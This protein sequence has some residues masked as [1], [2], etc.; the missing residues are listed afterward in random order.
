M[1]KLSVRRPIAVS[2]GY[3][4]VALLGVAAWRNI[5]VELMP[6]AD[7]PRLQITS[8]WRGASPE[9]MEAFVTAPLERTVQQVRGVEKITSRSEEE[10]G[11]GRTTIDVEFAR[12][13]DMDFARLE[14][15]E[16]LAAVERELPEAA[17]SPQVSPYVPD[18]FQDQNKAFLSYTVTAPFTLEAVRAHV[19]DVILPEILQVDGV[20][21]VRVWGGR[22]RLLELE[23]D[24][25]ELRS[26]GLTVNQIYTQVSS[27]EFV[28]EAGLVDDAGMERTLAIRQTAGSVDDIRNLVVLSSQGRHV[29]L[30]DIAIVRDTYED[31]QGYY[32]I[33]GNP[34]LAFQVYKEHGTNT[35]AAAGRVKAR[36]VEIERL[37]PA[38]LRLILDE[39]ESED[40]ETQL[41][42]LRERAVVAAIV[43]FSVLLIFLQS[44]RSAA[45]IFATIAFSILIA[46]NLIYFG[47][48]TLNVLTLMG[49]AMGF[50]LIVD[51][52]IVV[53]EN[54][55]RKRRGGE[56][57]KEAAFAGAKEV[58][59]PILAATLTTLIVFI[60]FVYLQGELRV[61]YV[62][63][64]IV[65]GMSLL[66][67]LVVAFSF[68]PAL[69]ARALEKGIV[70]A[71]ELGG[72]HAQK[73]PFYVRLYAGMVGFTTRYP[74]VT[75]V[76]AVIAVYASWT[77]FDKY[78][79]RG[80]VWGGVWG[81][82]TYISIR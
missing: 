18:E 50:G 58:V 74:W 70:V 64:A 67:S 15:S 21:D 68:I 51:N 28:S 48:L 54:I 20:A 34:A 22:D 8:N 13:T 10:Q 78:V 52:A 36:L 2:M 62:P 69:A 56:S 35:V 46:L 30:D 75:V 80:V 81:Q 16:G 65:V 60:P 12:N 17:R 42:D 72:D 26:L 76:S 38:G 31:P 55:Y 73:D 37:H 23:F 82:Q 24:E 32:R 19:D 39:D 53:L 7:L 63:L 25:T 4:A 79:N 3:V 61:Y 44:F 1:I 71:D 49:L 5:P 11:E 33:D 41:T 27:L 29:R 43:I 40:I 9:T 47:G 77:L 59:L 14:L 45:I 6:D 57:A 66:A